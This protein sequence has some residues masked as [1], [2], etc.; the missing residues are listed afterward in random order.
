MNQIFTYSVFI[1][2]ISFPFYNYALPSDSQ[3][4]AYLSADSADINNQTHKGIYLGNVMFDQGSSHLR[5]EKATTI[6]DDKN[7][8]DLVIIEGKIGKQAHFWTLTEIQKPEL[9]AYADL[10][11]F[12]PKINK[13]YLMGKAHIL[14][15]DNSYAAP[16][17]EYDTKNKHILSKSNR[18][19]RTLI[20]IHSKK[21][22]L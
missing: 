18:K 14:Q 4:P 15:A 6:T 13:L 19:E 17:I 9:H 5:A 20:I 16:F 7:Q 10:I 3:K 8:L 21:G 22:L 2:L 11:K 12:Y 1:C